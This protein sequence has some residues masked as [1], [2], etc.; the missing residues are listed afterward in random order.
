M[1]PVTYLQHAVKFRGKHHVPLRLE[2][3][4]HERP[5]AIKLPT[6]RPSR[7]RG[8][9]G[10]QTFPSANAWNVSSVIMSVTLGLAFPGLVPL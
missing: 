2:L 3:P 1:A 9:D 8:D 7:V 10:G 5:L 6:V 4:G